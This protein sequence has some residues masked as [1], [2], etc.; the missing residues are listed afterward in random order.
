MTVTEF[1]PTSE[2]C[3]ASCDMEHP[4]TGDRLSGPLL[5]GYYPMVESMLDG[6]AEVWIECEGRRVQF[7]AAHLKDVVKQLKRAHALAVGGRPHG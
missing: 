1:T 5:I 4:Q 2:V 7:L 3:I 6:E